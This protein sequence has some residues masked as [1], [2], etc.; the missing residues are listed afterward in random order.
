MSKLTAA[1]LMFKFLCLCHP[2]VPAIVA[3]WLR[4]NEHHQ[5]LSAKALCFF[6]LSILFIC[7]FVGMD[8]YCYHDISWT[9]STMFI[10][11]TGN[12]HKLLLIIW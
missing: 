9:P 5:T 11:L 12:I 2:S 8:R 6:G 7:H 3:E 1:S 10:K 4:T